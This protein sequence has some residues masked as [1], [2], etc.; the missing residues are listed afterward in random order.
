[1][2]KFI[3]AW[4]VDG[5]VMYVYEVIPPR[6]FHPYHQLRQIK[7]FYTDNFEG[8]VQGMAEDFIKRLEEVT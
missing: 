6:R 7:H 1:M 4:G 2:S 8:D 5:S 3:W